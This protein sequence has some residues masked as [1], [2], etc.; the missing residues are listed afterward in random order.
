VV[1][2]LSST[3]SSTSDALGGFDFFAENKQSVPSLSRHGAAKVANRVEISLGCKRMRAPTF[4]G[5]AAWL[6]GS[7]TG[8]AQNPPVDQRT[9]FPN[10]DAA[11]ARAL[12]DPKIPLD[13]KAQ[14]FALFDARLRPQE[15]EDQEG[16]TWLYRQG[17]K[18]VIIRKRDLS[19]SE[20]VSM[21]GSW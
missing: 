11:M 7:L 15:I 5:I 18:P 3:A 8:W 21:W 1:N 13:V 10:S 20:R 4:L 9:I 12:A 16:N 19:P 6:L 17:Q 2:I 14:L